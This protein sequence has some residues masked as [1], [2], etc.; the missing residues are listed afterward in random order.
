MGLDDVSKARSLFFY[1][2]VFPWSLQFDTGVPSIL[3]L[4]RMTQ[5][6]TF[7]IDSSL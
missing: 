1:K 5:G 2:V 3:Q 7:Q 6:P 4:A